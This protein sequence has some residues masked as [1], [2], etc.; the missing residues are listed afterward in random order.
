MQL[1]DPSDLP[2]KSLPGGAGVGAEGG[3][4]AELE[5]LPEKLGCGLKGVVRSSEGERHERPRVA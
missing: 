4:T 5:D 3:A 2:C 1:G